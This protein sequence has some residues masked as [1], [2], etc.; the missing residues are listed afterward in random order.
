M[1]LGPMRP[2]SRYTAG[3]VVAAACVATAS[4][5]QLPSRRPSVIVAPA[6]IRETV[7]W[8]AA[9]G[10]LR[11]S[12][13]QAPRAAAGLDPAAVDRTRMP[14]LLPDDLGFTGGARIYSFGDHYTITSDIRDG[15]VCLT[16]TTMTVPLPEPSRI[17]VPGAPEHLVVQ[18]TVG[19]LLASFVRYG[20]L[21]TIEV[22][23]DFAKDM[24]CRTETYVR[25]LL[26]KTTIVVMGRAARRAAGLR[27]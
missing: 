12:R 2:L 10:G 27:A 3:I 4:Q 26:A 16:G 18:R 25:Q 19:R 1:W 5:T 21:Y 7:D 17:V 15:A 13:A 24:R 9:T 22:R 23:C 8:A 14:I 11:R 20:V 6:P